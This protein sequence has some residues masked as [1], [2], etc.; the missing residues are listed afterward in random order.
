MAPGGVAESVVSVKDR[1]RVKLKHF[2]THWD[3]F[4]GE[5]WVDNADGYWAMATLE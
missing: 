5:K 2:M 4:D 1:V 3:K